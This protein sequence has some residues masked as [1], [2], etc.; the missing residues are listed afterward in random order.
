MEKKHD[1]R[2]LFYVWRLTDLISFWWPIFAD[3]DIQMFTE[4]VILFIFIL[5]SMNNLEQNGKSL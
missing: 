3:T 4:V 1:R 2:R 5:I